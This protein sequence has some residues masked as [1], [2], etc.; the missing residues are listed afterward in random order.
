MSDNKMRIHQLIPK[1]SDLAKQKIRLIDGKFQ[2]VEIIDGDVCIIGPLTVDI[3]SIEARL[4]SALQNGRISTMD[5][6]YPNSFHA[7]YNGFCPTC[8][9]LIKM[10]GKLTFLDTV[11][12]GKRLEVWKK[13]YAI[14]NNRLHE[15]ITASVL[16]KGHIPWIRHDKGNIE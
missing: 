1:K 3:S 9:Y 10:S 15:H 13:D 16:F 11:E 4:L 6:W 14:Y 12:D 7:T 5:R 2:L 8:R